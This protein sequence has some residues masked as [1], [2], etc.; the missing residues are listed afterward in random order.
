MRGRSDATPVRRDRT[1]RRVGAAA[2]VLVEAPGGFG[3][4]SFAAQLMA[5]DDQAAARAVVGDGGDVVAAVEH[6][7]RRHGLSDLAAV[8]G[9]GVEAFAAALGSR[10]GGAVLVVDEVQRATSEGQAWLVDLAGRVVR[11]SRLV[12]AG[13]RLGRE[14]ASAGDDDPTV[15]FVSADDLRFDRSET[16]LAV[17]SV[18]DAAGTPGVDTDVLDAVHRLT[19]GWP[20][21]VVLAAARL[22]GG[23][24]PPTS[25][26]SGSLAELVE[27]Q[28][29]DASPDAV[30]VVRELAHLPLLSAE[31]TAQ[32]VGP[33][34]LDVLLDVGLPVRFR[35]DGWAE[36]AD[37]VREHLIAGHTPTARVID[38]A[39]DVYARRGEL[40]AAVG[41]LSAHARAHR[42][43]RVLGSVGPVALAAL[44]AP[45]IAAAA[46]RLDELEPA[47]EPALAMLL[48]RLARA[49]EGIDPPLRARLL[50]RAARAAS[51]HGDAR[52]VRAVDVE[53]ARDVARRHDFAASFEVLE[54]VLPACEPDEHLTRGRAALALALGRLVDEQGSATSATIGLFEQAAAAFHAAGDPAGEAN[55]R[56][57]L[58]FGVHFN[59][60]AFDVAAGEMQRAAELLPAPDSARAMFL[61]F[62]AEIERDLGRLDAAETALYESL[63]IARRLGDATAVSYAAW[64]LAL[65]A[66]ERRDRAAVFRWID[67]TRAHAHAWIDAGAGVDYYGMVGEALVQLGERDAASAHIEAG[68]QHPSAGSY[69]WP[70]RSAR[71]RFEAVFG[72]PVRGEAVLDELDAIAPPRER[73]LRLLTRA[74]CAARR[75]DTA[76]AQSLLA[77]ADDAARAMDDPRRLERR[78]PEL[79]A[80]ARSTSA[81]GEPADGAHR[82]VDDAVPV[83]SLAVRMLGRFEVV[84]GGSI[85]T[86]PPGRAATLVK[87]VALR[88]ALTTD[89]AIDALW[90]DCDVDTGRARLR[91]LL[92]RVR[93]ASGPVIERTGDLLR[94]APDVEVDVD[95]FEAAAARA[96]VADGTADTTAALG[97]ARTALAA[98][99]GELLPSDAYEEWA[100]APRERLR[101]QWLSLVDLLARD[102]IAE[103][104]LDEALR[105]LDAGIAAEPYE[106]WRYVAAIDALRTQGRSAAA[107]ALARRGLE[108]L[109]ELGLPAD[110]RLLEAVRRDG[111]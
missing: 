102:A 42:L 15:V 80:I 61:T 20:A 35:P 76:R 94:L 33:G 111:G 16:E 54:R 57:A 100:A 17:R 47:D 24:H 51:V 56:R 23:G 75:G 32:A 29:A 86:P 106:A 70:V 31:V 99:G 7:L 66:A 39:A 9:A 12:V 68:E 41:L 1:L 79:L 96:T 95:R 6:A 78:E 110:D 60:G 88:G 27:R 81:A 89:A 72:D 8:A 37:P 90:D 109:D 67:E 28:L 11:P 93:T 104:L 43:V 74:A 14:L 30:A 19:A 25:A 22:A 18:L 84:S 108:A 46:D 59:R 10:D 105:L 69:V 34:A 73:P 107:A 97:A 101:R 53:L 4:S 5:V 98:Y 77:A 44:G 63:S 52:S 45:A 21:A 38:E 3:K 83:A 26:G 64:G 71:A 85:V 65:A 91:N 13:R 58:G 62:V 2:V 49:I 55:A 103:R 48:V 36:L 40:L 87:L 82:D 50:H 92:N